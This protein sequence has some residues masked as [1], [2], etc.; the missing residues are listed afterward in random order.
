[1]CVCVCV[2]VIVVLQME[3]AGPVQIPTETTFPLYQRISEKYE[4]NFFF[5]SIISDRA[6]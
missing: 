4:P 6:L 2:C 1:M 5:S 3:S